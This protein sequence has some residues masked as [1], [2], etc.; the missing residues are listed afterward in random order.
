M[1]RELT[2]I[3]YEHLTLVAMAEISRQLPYLR[4]AAVAELPDV[5]FNDICFSMN[6]MTN[7]PTVNI[8]TLEMLKI[9]A[10][11]GVFED[12]V[13][14]IGF[15]DRS[16]VVLLQFDAIMDMWPVYVQTVYRLVEID[17]TGSSD[18]KLM[19]VL[20][21]GEASGG[22]RRESC[23]LKSAEQPQMEAEYDIIDEIVRRA[24]ERLEGQPLLCDFEYADLVQEEAELLVDELGDGLKSAVYV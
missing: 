2:V 1:R 15:Y 23:F 5:D 21:A 22:K 3:D 20:E 9:D 18:A 16:R 4:R 8:K 13:Q 10:Y 19:S 24:N 12:F 6:F 17:K 11:K 14:R 7:P